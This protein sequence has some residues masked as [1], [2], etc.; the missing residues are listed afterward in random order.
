MKQL[1]PLWVKGIVKIKVTGHYPER[2]FD[3]CA[4]NGITIWSIQKRSQMESFGDIYLSDIRK[5]RKIRRKTRY[6]VTFVQKRGLPFFLK[7]LKTQYH[8]VL[9]FI[10]ASL[11]FLYLTQSI[12]FIDIEGVSA[13]IESDLRDT[14]SQQGIK[15]GKLKLLMDKPRSE[16]RRVGNEWRS[17]RQR[18][19]R[20]E[21]VNM[22]GRA[23][24]RT[25]Y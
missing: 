17:L 2:F 9:T 25:M 18:S 12:W 7:K 15:R 5:I 23:S 13:E 11:F 4:R 19:I 14:L 3:L 1:K 22:R 8:M 21:T 24:L 6:K 20:R 10:L 16:E